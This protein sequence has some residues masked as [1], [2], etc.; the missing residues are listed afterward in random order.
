VISEEKHVRDLLSNFKD[1]SAAANAAKGTILATPTLRNNFSY[2]VAHLSMTLQ[3]GQSLQE[4]N[5]SIS[6]TNTNKGYGR[7]GGR[8]GGR[9]KNGRGRGRGRNIYL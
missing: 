6:S 7:G 5:H 1:S 9:G 2:A 4:N 8:G 3:I